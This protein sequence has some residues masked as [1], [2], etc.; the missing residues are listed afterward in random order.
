MRLAQIKQIGDLV[1]LMGFLAAGAGY[2]ELAGGIGIDD[3]LHFF[4]LFGIG[5]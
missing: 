4:K 3:P 5:D 1:V 2:D